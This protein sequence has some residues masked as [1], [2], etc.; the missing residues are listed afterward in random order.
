MLSTDPASPRIGENTIRVTVSDEKGKPL[1][2][3]TVQLTYTMPMP[4]MSPA[5]IPMVLAKEGAYE[6]T[7]NL[8][9]GGQWDLT[10]T[11][12]VRVTPT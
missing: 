10:V 12:N 9:M 6:A 5:T 1:S 4:G 3:A 11:I 2:K 8:G 7:A